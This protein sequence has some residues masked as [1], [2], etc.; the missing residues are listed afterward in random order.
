M[1]SIPNRYA[2]ALY[3][4]VGSDLAKAK[5]LRESFEGINQ[6]FELKD[7][8]RVLKSPVMPPD[9]KKKLLDYA[10]DATEAA[11]EVKKLTTALLAAGRVDLLPEVAKSFYALLDQADG[12]VKSD[13][14]AAVP[15]TEADTKSIGDALSKLLAK[16]VEI[17]PTVDPSILGGF[18]ARVGNYRVDMSLKT[19]LDGLSQSAVQDSIR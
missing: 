14:T 19:K 9:L 17:K 8:A 3:Q 7:S 16:K 6:L 5:K 15:L 13:V 10:M 11:P 1:A 18:V 2:K 12:V 4:L